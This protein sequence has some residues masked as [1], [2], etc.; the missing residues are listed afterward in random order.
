M[1]KKLSVVLLW[2]SEKVSKFLYILRR[3]LQIWPQ[4]TGVPSGQHG[5]VHDIWYPYLA[6]CHGHSGGGVR[7]ARGL[8]IAAGGDTGSMEIQGTALLLGFSHLQWDLH[9]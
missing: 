7:P 1:W 4:N 5:S 6:A 2:L 8:L 9:S 3:L